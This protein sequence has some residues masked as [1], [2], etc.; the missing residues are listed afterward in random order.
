MRNIIIES[1]RLN[2]VRDLEQSR[3]SQRETLDTLADDVP[4]NTWTT[5]IESGILVEAGDTIRLESAVVQEL[6]S[7]SDVIEL[8]GKSGNVIQAAPGIDP[9]Y[10]GEVLSDNGV[11]LEVGYYITNRQQFNF[12]LPKDRFQTNYAYKSNGYGGPAFYE[13]TSQN[14]DPFTEGKFVPTSWACFEKCYPYQYVEGAAVRFSTD[15]TTSAFT[16]TPANN[17]APPIPPLYSPTFTDKYNPSNSKPPSELY[18]PSTTRNY[19]GNKDYTGPYHQCAP[20]SLTGG[21]FADFTGGRFP[22]PEYNLNVPWDYFKSKVQLEVETGFSTPAA[23]AETLTSQLHSRQGDADAWSVEESDAVGFQTDTTQPATDYQ[24]FGGPV[25]PQV[26]PYPTVTDETYRTF[27]TTTGKMLYR[28]TKNSARTGFVQA[29]IPPTAADMAQD[30]WVCKFTD[31]AIVTSNVVLN[32]NFERGENYSRYQGQSVYYSHMMSAKPNYVKTMSALNLYA[33][34]YPKFDP[35][36]DFPTNNPPANAPYT[37]WTAINSA[38]A[39]NLP[40]T[41]WESYTGAT[42]D[43]PAHGYQVG[44]IGN[45]IVLLNKI[46]EIDNTQPFTY[47]ANRTNEMKTE[48]PGSIK[49]ANP[50]T[51][52]IF[53]TNLLWTDEAMVHMKRIFDNYFDVIYATKTTDI[54]NDN[55][56]NAHIM[57]MNYG[58]LDDMLTYPGPPE[59]IDGRKINSPHRDQ[60]S[61]L[62][63]PHNI[64]DTRWLG[65]NPTLGYL[66]RAGSQYEIFASENGRSPE[67]DSTTFVSADSSLPGSIS[68]NGNELYMRHYLNSKFTAYNAWYGILPNEPSNYFVNRPPASFRNGAYN[69]FEKF[70]ALWDSIPIVSGGGRLGIIPQ[71]VSPT[72]RDGGGSDLPYYGP[73]SVDEIYIA[74]IYEDRPWYGAVTPEEKEALLYPWPMRTEFFGMSPSELTCHYSQIVTTQKVV[75]TSGDA[76]RG[77]L[78]PQAAPS[79][80]VITPAGKAE[81]YPTPLPP[82]IPTGANAAYLASISSIFATVSPEYYMPYI[83]VGSNDAS[84][85]FD[86]TLSRFSLR[87]FHTPIK[88]GNGSFAVPLLVQESSPEQNIIAWQERGAHLSSRRYAGPDNG[89]PDSGPGTNKWNTIVARVIGEPSLSAQAG[90]GIVGIGIICTNGN[91]LEDRKV[92]PLSTFKSLYFNNTLLSKV[93]FEFEQLLPKYG[94]P[95]NQF[96]RGNANKYLG[97]GS[98]TNVLKKMENFV[99]P[100][101]TNAYVSAAITIGLSRL[102]KPTPIDGSITPD[103][104]FA[105]AENLGGTISA[106][107]VNTNATSDELVALNLPRKLDGSYLVVYSNIV[108]APMYY[109]GFGSHGRLPCIGYLLKNYSSGDYFYS[110]QST[111]EY[112]AEIDYVLTD[113]LVDIRNPDSSPARIGPENSLMFKIQKRQAMPALPPPPKEK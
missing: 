29:E 111:I 4:N 106:V 15:G 96:N 7:G 107:A 83:S 98:G 37:I 105:P 39:G 1:N 101:T 22:L 104:I 82:G 41:R 43:V 86:T 69:T 16:V 27:P 30:K 78:T 103:W 64:W 79:Q 36:V 80:S 58:R 77:G 63:C 25:M 2:S 60:Q 55:F 11:E 14:S 52:D 40:D 26:T 90:I 5:T 109:G 87:K 93:G 70:Q 12:N 44:N 13:G 31:P 23:I 81:N 75:S 45:N 32:P 56:L 113:I 71:F 97:F 57:K 8:T 102:T 21:G 74:F 54:N 62:A 67:G 35:N 46:A 10:V 42:A 99:S 20:A 84:I 73:G 34:S 47:Y 112:I 85:F 18:S 108:R 17:V 6:G 3:L 28:R 9:I 92:F 53:V 94:R 91:I 72:R 24:G 110:F 50:Q 89:T 51:D 48:V 19:I 76:T 95:Q 66:N 65:N 38:R 33:Q 49:L 68:G 59:G 88:K 61:F 100:F